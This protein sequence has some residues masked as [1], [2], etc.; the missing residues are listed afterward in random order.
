MTAPPP[1][2]VVALG[3]N[4]LSPRGEPDTIATQFRRTRQ[5]LSA[6]LHLIRLG[7]RLVITHGNGPQVGNALLRT[8]LTADQAPILPLGVCVAD[9]QGGMG[10][11]I[12]QSLQNLLK[13]ERIDRTVVTLIT[14]VLVREDDPEIAAPTKFIG[15][16]YAAEQARK[17][18]DR[19]GWSIREE[20]P[21]EWRRVV[22]S[23]T[24]ISLLERD[25]IRELVRSGKIVIAA[26]GGG[27]PVWVMANGNLEGF[28]AVVDKDL[29]S[30]VLGNEIDADELFML[31]DVEGVAVYWGTSRQAFLSRLTAA[32][33][34]QLA[35]EGQFPAGSMRPKMEAAT[36]FLR[37]GGKRVFICSLDGIPGALEGQS[38]T[39][40]QS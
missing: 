7:Y 40:I 6:I 23:P 5:S 20:T 38:G 22:P 33:A 31:T 37:R 16:R 9:T 4:A 14:Q 8:E 34:E 13:R 39:M 27:I 3:G 2:A 18:S 35:R 21:G 24:P 29:A 11:M 19:F 26:G 36:R 17:L 30:S 28:D 32:E 12:Q 10:Y 15:Q 1:L 25:A